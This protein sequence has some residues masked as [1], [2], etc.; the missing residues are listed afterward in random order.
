MLNP[1]KNLDRQGDTSSS[2]IV[3]Y[4]R[5]A[6]AYPRHVVLF[7]YGAF[8]TGYLAAADALLRHARPF[9]VAHG[10]GWIAGAYVTYAH[11]RLDDGK[12][13]AALVR[14]GQA[15]AIANSQEVRP[16]TPGDEPLPL[17]I[18]LDDDDG[19]VEVETL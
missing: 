4:R 1:W 18:P 12:A 7:Q 5:L 13:V 3:Q 8:G 11:V 6:A 10:Q 19:E 14:A 16:S 17:V 9:V 2:D 15:V